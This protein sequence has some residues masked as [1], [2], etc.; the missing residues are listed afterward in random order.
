MVRDSNKRPLW[1][2]TFIRGRRLKREAFISYFRLF[3]DLYWRE[4]FKRR[5]SSLEELRYFRSSDLPQ[6]PGRQL[7]LVVARCRCKR[8]KYVSITTLRQETTGSDR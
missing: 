3:G 7:S 6:R 4:A 8:L 5:G 2:G 1:E